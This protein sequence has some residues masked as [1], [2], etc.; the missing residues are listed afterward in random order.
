M[1]CNL[2]KNTT[3]ECLI[4]YLKKFG[5]QDEREIESIVFAN[6]HIGN[7]NRRRRIKQVEDFVDSLKLEV[8]LFEKH[9]KEERKEDDFKSNEEP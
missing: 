2:W 5:L 9:K 7:I 6:A 4:E 3:S 8:E 1:V